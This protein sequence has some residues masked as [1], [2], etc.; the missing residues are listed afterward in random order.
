MVFGVRLDVP[1]KMAPRDRQDH[2]DLLD[3]LDH[4]DL[5]V[6]REPLQHPLLLGI[7]MT[8]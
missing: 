1:E 8:E 3:L 7:G 2:R 6:Q 4:R 5:R